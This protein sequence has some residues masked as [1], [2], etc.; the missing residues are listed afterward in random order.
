MPGS[1]V[2]PTVG[3]R[4]LGDGSEANPR[5][6]RTGEQSTAAAHGTW[7]EALRVGNIWTISTPLAGI[8]VTANMLTSVASSNCI[9]GLYNKGGAMA[10]ILRAEIVVGSN[11]T[12]TGFNW[13]YITPTG[14]SPAPTGVAKA[15]N[16][17]TLALG[18]SPTTVA[19]D[20]SV[21]VSGSGVTDLFRPIVAGLVNTPI[22]VEEF[23]D[24]LI[25]PPNGFIGIFGDT[26]TTAAVV[27]AA[28]TWED[29]PL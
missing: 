6:T 18:S 24:D 26:V 3:V 20:G 4:V 8:T 13:G 12:A 10:H 22:T 21:A 11:A 28:I 1:A 7:L 14:I 17:K 15:K 2:N 29:V 19:F 25:V 27:K 23:D 9:V 5:V 16:H